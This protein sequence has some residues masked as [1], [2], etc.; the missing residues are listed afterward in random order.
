MQ[1]RGGPSKKKYELEIKVPFGTI[2]L[3][4][5]SGQSFALDLPK[6]T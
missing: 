1:K 6:S 4:T 3:R 2:C 5:L